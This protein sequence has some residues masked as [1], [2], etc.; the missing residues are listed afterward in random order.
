MLQLGADR[1]PGMK[2]PRQRQLYAGYGADVLSGVHVDRVA[3]ICQHGAAAQECEVLLRGRQVEHARHLPQKLHDS[4]VRTDCI[5]SS[6][7]KTVWSAARSSKATEQI[8]KYSK[9]WLAFQ[10]LK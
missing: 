1:C 5:I 6:A 10:V 4:V 7:Q 8:T 2:G 3:Q 9:C